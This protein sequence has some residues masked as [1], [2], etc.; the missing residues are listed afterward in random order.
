MKD[1]P[2]QITPTADMQ[3]YRRSLVALQQDAQVDYDKAILTLS[4]G[5]LGISFAFFRDITA[6]LTTTHAGFLLGA[7]ICW[8]LSLT[9]ALAGFYTSVGAF[10]KIIQQIDKGREPDVN[11]ANAPTKLLNKVAGALF[12]PGVFC[13]ILFLYQNLR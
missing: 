13:A 5:A 6:K 10:Q 2:A 9:A 1:E 11:K 3:E 4:G 8:A 12:V 7:W